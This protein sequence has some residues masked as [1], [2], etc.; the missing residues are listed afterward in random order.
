MLKYVPTLDELSILIVAD[1]HWTT[2]GLQ[3]AF[4][5][6]SSVAIAHSGEHAV[7]LHNELQPDIT[8]MDINLGPGI[9]GI[10][11]I[12]RIRET[13]PEARIVVLTTIA[14][15]PGLG[16]ALE[17][18]AVAVVRK[19][20]EEE[21]LRSVVVS[22]VTSDDPRWLKTLA[23][24]IVISGDR[25]PDAPVKNPELTRAE[26]DTLLLVTQGFTYAEIAMQ[27]HVSAWTVQTH[28]KHLREKLH[29]SNLAQ[30]VVRALQYHYI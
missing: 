2:R 28:V 25:L 23:Q 7:T 16:R 12:Y 29:A 26:L 6:A 4:R 21:A 8:L 24:D 18:G 3:L 11:T 19:T 27:Q 13:T 30:L 1:D 22:A 17:A 20:T 9:S 14:P 15:G 5:E 10:E